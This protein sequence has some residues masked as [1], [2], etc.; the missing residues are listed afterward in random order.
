MGALSR[1]LALVQG[2]SGISKSYVAVQ[3]MKVLLK[4]RE[5]AEMEHHAKCETNES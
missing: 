4:R 1:D 3:A 2:P 5:S